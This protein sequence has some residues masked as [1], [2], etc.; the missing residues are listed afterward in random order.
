M[1]CIPLYARRT[2][3]RSC[4]GVF[5]LKYLFTCILISEFT[6]E[7]A[8]GCASKA[9]S[10]AAACNQWPYTSRPTCHTMCAT[11]QRV[12]Q[13]YSTYSKAFNFGLRSV[14]L[15]PRS[16]WVMSDGRCASVSAVSM[17]MCLSSVTC[18]SCSCVSS[19]T[20]V[21]ICVPHRNSNI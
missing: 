4:R 13:G 2:S 16:W 9:W 12:I 15:W 7:N 5:S 10:V 18:V 19:V 21:I 1:G 20:L 6:N 14:A 11:M 8:R 17:C 3:P